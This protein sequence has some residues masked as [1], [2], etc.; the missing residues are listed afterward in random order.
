MNLNEKLIALVDMDYFFAQC[1][2]LRNPNLKGKPVA[3]CM[4]TAPERGAISSANYL[5]R[6]LG[7]KVGMPVSSAKRQVNDLVILPVDMPYYVSISSKIMGALAKLF[8]RVEVASIDE[9]YVE[10]TA[11]NYDEAV[12]MGNEIKEAV[13]NASGITC[14]VGI[15]QNKLIAKMACDSSKPNGLKVIMPEHSTEFIEK[16]KLNEIP[17]IG[18]KTAERLS[19][20]GCNTVIDAKKL[21]YEQLAHEFGQK[22]GI[23]IYNALRGIDERPLQINRVRK[24]YEKFATLGQR[25]PYELVDELA[26]SLFLRLKGTKFQEIGIII[27]YEDMAVKTKARTLKFYANDMDAIKTEGKQLLKE[28]LALNDRKIRRIGLKVSKLKQTN[29][30]SLSDYME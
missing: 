3:V 10:I 25:D 12:K 30:L 13:F 18:H 28:I 19:A 21:S 4:L 26:T 7:A 11:I 9:A 16:S 8:K 2:E 6:K 23:F 14:T 27:I 15:G 1:E 20:M 22:K 5:A 17:Y 24:E 29:F